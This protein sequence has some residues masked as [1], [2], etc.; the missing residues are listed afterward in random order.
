VRLFFY[1]LFMADDELKDPIPTGWLQRGARIV[2]ATG[3]S[4]SRFMGTRLKSFAAPDRAQ[5]FVQGFHEETAQ[6]LVGMLGEMKGAAMKLGQLA[7]FYEFAT[8]GEYMATYR[9]AMT[10]LQNS[11]P[12]MDAA[13]ARG[14][15]IGRAH[16]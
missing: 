8:P 12:P 2:G 3:K 6:Q 5:E 13:T 11:A 14:V 15:E 7:S 9:D 10:M 1:H 4:A 16:V